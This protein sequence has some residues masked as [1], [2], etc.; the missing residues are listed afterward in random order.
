M[1]PGLPTSELGW[2]V[3]IGILGAGLAL[4]VGMCLGCA[5]EHQVPSSDPGYLE[6]LLDIDSLG[7]V[8]NHYTVFYS[9]PRPRA[10]LDAQY[11]SARIIAFLKKEPGAPRMGQTWWDGRRAGNKKLLHARDFWA[12]VLADF[13]GIKLTI[14]DDGMTPH[15]R[16][17]ADL[18][19]K[20]QKPQDNIEFRGRTTQ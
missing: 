6:E 20:L 5:R 7:C 17:I 14:P 11:V 19:E 8:F 4:S 3:L 10:D 12:M 18:L 15:E 16:E 2:R 9:P 1:C 13:N